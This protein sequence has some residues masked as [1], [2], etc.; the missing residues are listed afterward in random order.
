MAIYLTTVVLDQEAALLGV[1][2]K[3]TVAGQV[4]GTQ[5]TTVIQVRMRK[6]GVELRVIEGSQRGGRSEMVVVC[7]D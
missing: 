3:V 4:V 5:K 7:G 1:K 6:I 2:K